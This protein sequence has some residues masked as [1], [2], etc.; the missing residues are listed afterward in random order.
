VTTGLQPLHAVPGRAFA[1]WSGGLAALVLVTRWPIRSHYLFSWDAANFAAAL[2]D[3]NVAFHHP[4]PPGYP[5][6]IGAAWLLRPLVGGANASFVALSLAASVGAVV[7]LL[8]LSWR[9]YGPHI[10]L[11]GTTLFAASPNFWGHGAVAYS[12][13]FLALG[14]TLVAWCAAETRWGGRDMVLAGAAAL[15]VAGGF[16]PDLVVFLLPVWVYGSFPLGWRRLGGGVAVMAVVVAG[17]LGPTVALSGGWGVYLATSSAYARAWAVPTDAGWTALVVGIAA[18]VGLLAAFA[19]RSLGPVWLGLLVFG[20]GRLFAPRALA[21]DRR[22]WL[23]LLWLMPA[24]SFYALVH[25]GNLGY[26]LSVLPACAMAGALAIA[27]LAGELVAVAPA[28]LANWAG[29]R[30]ALAIAI[31]GLACGTEALL[32]LFSNGPVSWHEIRAVDRLLGAEVPYLAALPPDRTLVLAYDRFAQL[33]HYLPALSTRGRIRSMDG[34][35]GPDTSGDHHTDLVVPN[36]VN[37]VV[38]PDLGV[39]AADRPN[40]VRR[41]SL[42]GGVWVYEARVRAGT[43]LRLGYGYAR[44]VG[45]ADVTAGPLAPSSATSVVPA[46]APGLGG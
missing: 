37:L 26:L 42:G 10:A 4:H 35:L 34:L 30:R 18:N 7:L 6:Y 14:A 11:L 16:R 41:V 20:V 29:L 3:F 38:L 40:G 19:A 25:I 15:G 44:V 43:H 46:H 13:P 1:I 21:A 23:L 31:G 24:L 28:R 22:T 45:A 9:L 5:L 8:G 2:D 32:F 17:W 39:D 33:E 27:D 36:G 12:Y